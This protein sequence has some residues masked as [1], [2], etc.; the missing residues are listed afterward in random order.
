[1]TPPG[2]SQAHFGVLTWSQQVVDAHLEAVE[3][4]HGLIGSHCGVAETHRRGLKLKEVT[5]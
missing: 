1:M 4:R 5:N 2:L 3:A